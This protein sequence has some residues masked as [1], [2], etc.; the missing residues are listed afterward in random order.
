MSCDI[1]VCVFRYG[2]SWN[3]NV[4]GN[5]LSASDD[6]VRVIVC[7]LVAGLNGTSLLVVVLFSVN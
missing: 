7:S 5:L 6:H 1:Y 2:L 3:P 4:N